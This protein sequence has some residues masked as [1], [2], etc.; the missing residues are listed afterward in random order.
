VIST[1]GAA[2]GPGADTQWLRMVA[3]CLPFADWRCRTDIAF[4]NGGFTG[5]LWVQIVSF[6]S[7]KI[8]RESPESRI[9]RCGLAAAMGPFG[10]AGDSIMNIRDANKVYAQRCGRILYD[11]RKKWDPDGQTMDSCVWAVT[12]TKAFL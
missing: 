9:R 5:M 4:D 2:G 12:E 6:G 3:R 10:Q 8:R 11:V 7:T 1:H